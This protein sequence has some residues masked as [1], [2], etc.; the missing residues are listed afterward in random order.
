VVSG[1]DD[2]TIKVWDTRNFKSPTLV[3]R[4]NAGVNRLALSPSGTALSVPLDNRYVELYSLSGHKMC[5]LSRREGHQKMAT[6]STWV[7]EQAVVT[8]GFDG[9]A[10]EWHLAIPADGFDARKTKAKRSSVEI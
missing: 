2:R 5:R 6:S 10:L 3:I 9:E 8:A 1:S 7:G 4:L